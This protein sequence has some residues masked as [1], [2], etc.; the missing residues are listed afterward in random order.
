MR[1]SSALLTALCRGLRPEIAK[2]INKVPAA[3]FNDWKK[4]DTLDIQELLN[5][6]L[7]LGFPSDLLVMAMAQ[8]LAPRVLQAEGYSSMPIEVCRSIL[9]GCILSV[10]V[11]LGYIYLFKDMVKLFK[12]TPRSKCNHFCR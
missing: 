3:V 6:A 12:K 4:I 7:E 2:Y 1:G 8:H 11:L 10:C 9:Q 5:N